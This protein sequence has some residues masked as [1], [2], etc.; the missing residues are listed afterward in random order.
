MKKDFEKCKKCGKG[1]ND[2]MSR[3]RGYG[4]EC[5]KS[6]DKIKVRVLPM[7]NAKG[8]YGDDYKEGES[9][10]ICS[11]ASKKYTEEI[12]IFADMTCDEVLENSPDYIF[13]LYVRKDLVNATWETLLPDGCNPLNLSKATHVPVAKIS[14]WDDKIWR[15]GGLKGTVDRMTKTDEIVIPLDW[16]EEG[17]TEVLIDFKHTKYELEIDSPCP[18]KFVDRF[19]DKLYGWAEYSIEEQAGEYAWEYQQMLQGDP[20]YLSYVQLPNQLPIC[21]DEYPS[22]ADNLLGWYD[23]LLS[24][25]TG[26]R[27][28][29]AIES[30]YNKLKPVVKSAMGW[31]IDDISEILGNNGKEDWGLDWA[32]DIF[33]DWHSDGLNHGLKNVIQ[34]NLFAWADC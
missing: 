20:R 17:T 7:K 10:R 12:L 16:C 27:D 18:F 33:D 28:D 30:F 8:E 11:F 23:V 34:E 6:V 24:E 5:W 14:T 31:V 26:V 9:E 25:F 13:L 15:P 19:D 32:R 29:R 1:L 4:P 2:K 3:L 21:R 22:S